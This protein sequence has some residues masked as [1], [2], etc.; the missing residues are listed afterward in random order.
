MFRICFVCC[1]VLL[2]GCAC[3]SAKRSDL[4]L[5]MTYDEV[6]KIVGMNLVK[7]SVNG[8]TYRGYT[9][10]DQKPLGWFVTT[11]AGD[12]HIR[13]WLLTFNQSNRLVSIE[14]DGL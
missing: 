8:C 10:A 5:G 1:L 6:S 12:P 4:K 7:E 11:F 3:V 14:Y 13:A 9:K 2:S